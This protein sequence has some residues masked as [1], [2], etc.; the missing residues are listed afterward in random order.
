MNKFYRLLYLIVVCLAFITVGYVFVLSVL[1]KDMF[2]IT[3]HGFGLMFLMYLIFDAIELLKGKYKYLVVYK[4]GKENGISGDG[5]V[6]IEVNSPIE[7]QK[8]VENI[9]EYIK[10][11]YECKNAFITNYIKLKPNK[12]ERKP[13][14][15][16]R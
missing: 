11:E 2:K 1:D 15:Q 16:T 4:Y 13:N 7:T 3:L 9:E 6:Y 10:M 12:K 14:E 5:R 8:D